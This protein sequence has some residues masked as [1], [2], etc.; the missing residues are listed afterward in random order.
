MMQILL[1]I[2]LGIILVSMVINVI[3]EQKEVDIRKSIVNSFNDKPKK[4]QFKVF[5]FL[6]KKNYDLNSE[7]ALMRYEIF[8]TNSKFIQE[9]NSKN[10][11]YQ[12]ELNHSAD[13]TLEEFNKGFKEIISEEKFNKDIQKFLKSAQEKK[14]NFDIMADKDDALIIKNISKTEQVKKQVRVNW[15]SKMNPARDQGICG[16]STAFAA[17]ASIE[18]NYNKKFGDSPIFSEQEIVD[19]DNSNN[20][21]GGEFPEYNI[22]YISENGLAYADEYP[23]SSGKTN[24][25]EACRSSSTTRHMV[26]EDMEMCPVYSCEKA[27]LYS[28]LE[29]GP[30]VV[31]FDSGSDTESAQIFRFYA[32]GIL[33]NYSCKRLNHAVVLIGSDYDNKGQ[34][35]I[36]RNSFGPDWGDKGNFMIRVDPNN[37]DTCFMERYGVLPV[38]KKITNRN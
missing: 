18:G 30:V 29:K 6:Y 2:A 9:V 10:L 36:G 17:I 14:I 25:K 23:Y 7:E 11:S 16:S 4:E 33:E 3:I 31:F 24:K 8:K 37:K 32:K 15:A 26:I 19:C 21:C 27:Q 12:L 22:G 28:M 34:Y 1:K 13:L 35:L 20:V 5:H 38:V